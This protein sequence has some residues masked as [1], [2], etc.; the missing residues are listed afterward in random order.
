MRAKCVLFRFVSN[1]DVVLSARGLSCAHAKH[2]HTHKKLFELFSVMH[3][4][5]DGRTCR[6]FIFSCSLFALLL[7][8]SKCINKCF[9]VLYRT[10]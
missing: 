4:D 5:D 9:V 1:D 6:V 2:T 10:E 3:D 7:Y 8:I